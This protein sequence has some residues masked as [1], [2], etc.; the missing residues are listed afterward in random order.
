MIMLVASNSFKESSNYAV[1]LAARLHV[2]PFQTTVA[3]KT[4]TLANVR[5]LILMHLLRRYEYSKY[6]KWIQREKKTD[7][8]WEIQPTNAFELNIKAQ[9]YLI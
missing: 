5:P 3:N 1:L 8:T 6:F 7:R 4:E 9:V 2:M